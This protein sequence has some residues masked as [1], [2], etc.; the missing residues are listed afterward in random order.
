MG[1]QTFLFSSRQSTKDITHMRKRIDVLLFQKG[2]ARSR[3]AAEDLIKRGVVFVDGSAVKKPSEKYEDDV[4]CHIS[5][6]VSFVG[7]GGLKLEEALRAFSI[8]PAG[9]VIV[10]IGSSTGGFTD[11]LLKKKAAKVF[12]ID[13]GLKQLAPELRADPRVVVMEQTAVQDATIAK[14]ADGAVIDVSFTPLN[15]ILPHAVRL[16]KK[17]AWIIALL[18]PQFEVG[19]ADI[20]RH[21]IVKDETIGATLMARIED[22]G[23][24]IGLRLA[25]SIASPIR[26]KGGNQEYLMYFQK[27]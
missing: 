5:E 12:A 17:D 21:G 10:D 24:K 16:T 1:M 3:S 4:V 7:R 14:E 23:K 26:G 2:L 27:Q 6:G 25:G 18:K 13:I 11:C 8:A 20:T 22:E 9:K 15:Q 19:P